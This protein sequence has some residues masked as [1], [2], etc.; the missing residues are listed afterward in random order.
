MIVFFEENESFQLDCTVRIPRINGTC[1]L[2]QRKFVC[3][4]KHFQ[5]FEG[6][7]LLKESENSNTAILDPFQQIVF[8]DYPNSALLSSTLLRAVKLESNG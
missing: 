3:H 2:K 7:R 1:K 8:Q 4:G 6:D 5:N